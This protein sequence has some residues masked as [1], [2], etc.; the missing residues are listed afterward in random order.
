[1]IFFKRKK[2]ILIL[3][4]FFFLFVFDKAGAATLYI[5]PS[6]TEVS[7]GNIVNVQISVDTSGKFINNAE[8]IVSFPKDLLEVVSL[9]NKS[10]I[11]SL[12]VENPSFSN[13]IGQAT[14]N[15]GVPNPGFQGGN[16]NI[17]SIIFKTKKVGTAS[18]IFS[19]K[20]NLRSEEHT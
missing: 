8:S 7:V 9:D 14:F 6:Q 4:L 3:S 18:I 12:W 15:G 11:F 2:Y 5:K 19:F 10:S 20:N 1:M 17:I 13:S 16:G